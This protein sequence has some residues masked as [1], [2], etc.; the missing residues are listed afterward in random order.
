MLCVRY[1]IATSG[2]LT[3]I[4]PAVATVRH[5]LDLPQPFCAGYNV[6]R[7]LLLR[8]AEDSIDETPQ[9]A[10]TLQTSGRHA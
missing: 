3:D 2:S 6:P 10:S 5:M 7:N 8:F 9:L 4:G 1:A